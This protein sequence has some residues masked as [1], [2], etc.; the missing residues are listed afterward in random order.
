VRDLSI[1]LLL[2]NSGIYD[3]QPVRLSGQLLLGESTALL[4]DQLGSGG[5]PT[6]NAQQ[7]KLVGPIEGDPLRERLTATT[8][9]AARFGPVKI[10]GIWR[11]GTIYPLA[12]IPG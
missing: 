12:I 4:V 10:V 3:N 6:S 9:G 7:L 1:R 5:V 11:R 2:D 8:G